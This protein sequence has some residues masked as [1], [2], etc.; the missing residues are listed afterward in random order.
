MKAKNVWLISALIIGLVLL[1]GVYGTVTDFLA[2]GFEY[3]RII[4]I[5]GHQKV[6]K[7]NLSAMVFVN[8]YLVMLL[9]LQLHGYLVATD[10]ETISRKPE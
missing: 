9:A 2:Y 4:I 1:G 5:Q 3:E 7:V 10:L 8:F 6:E